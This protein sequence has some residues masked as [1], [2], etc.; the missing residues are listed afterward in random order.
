MVESLK[1]LH[2]GDPGSPVD[3]LQVSHNA[4]CVECAFLRF[5]PGIMLLE[6]LL[7]EHMLLEHLECVH[8]CV[9]LINLLLKLSKMSDLS[10]KKEVLLCCV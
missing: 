1:L 10:H 4:S 3:G 9:G 5:W 2:E 7:Q 8:G 6:Q